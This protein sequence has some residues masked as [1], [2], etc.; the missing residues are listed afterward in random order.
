VFLYS[1]LPAMARSRLPEF[2]SPSTAELRALWRNVSSASDAP[3]TRLL[4]SEIIRTRELISELDS[5]CVV[6]QRAWSEEAHAKLVALEKM[7]GIFARERI[8]QGVLS[9]EPP[10]AAE[11]TPES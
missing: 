6:V 8:V 2:V 1:I 11:D 9:G 4:I 5:F 3:T 10:P 7:R